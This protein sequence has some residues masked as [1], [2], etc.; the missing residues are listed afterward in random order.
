SGK[1]YINDKEIKI[2][3]PVDAKEQG[4]ALL[5]EERRSTGIFPVLSVADNVL[6]ASINKYVKHKFI[7][8]KKKSLKDIKINIDK[9][10]IKTPSYK[11]QIQY[12]SG[13]N[14]QKVI[15]SRWLLMDP[16]I[17]ILDEPTRGIDVGAKYEIYTII[18]DLAKQ[19]K[20]IIMIS[21]EMP[22]LIG[23]SDRIM[24]M[25][26]GKVSGIIDGKDA[27]QEDIMKLATKFA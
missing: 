10:R 18:A 20:S 22:E 13:G 6:M 27:N 24:V 11:T 5:T 8:N 4:I 26:S 7:L 2:K 19:G 14:Q 3:S 21:S 9:L 25:C 16:D 1:L 12:L 17:L 15:F 23:M